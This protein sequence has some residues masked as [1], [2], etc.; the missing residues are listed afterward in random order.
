MQRAEPV[1][2]AFISWLR[3]AVE[4]SGKSSVGGYIVVQVL[5]DDWEEVEDLEAGGHRARTRPRSSRG[6]ARCLP[7]LA[8]F[9]DQK[10][11][12]LHSWKI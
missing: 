9:I 1:R 6:F 3:P 11:D 4:S 7:D 2:R 8:G 10:A 5:G 12:M